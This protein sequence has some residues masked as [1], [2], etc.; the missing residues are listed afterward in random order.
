MELTRSL[1]Q[2]EIDGV[3]YDVFAEA[4][5]GYD[6][7]TKILTVTLASYL[8]PDN[9]AR[10]N[11]RTVPEWL[12]A[13]Q[14]DREHVDADEASDLAKDVFQRWC[15]KVARAVPDLRV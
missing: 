1:G 5:A 10:L 6:A 14:V 13:K 12:P 11:E 2:V 9:V 8:M 4:H 3:K 15:S 7:P